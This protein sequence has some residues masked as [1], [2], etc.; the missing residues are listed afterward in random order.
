MKRTMIK[1]MAAVLSV[2]LTGALFAGCGKDDKAAADTKTA[3]EVK[4]VT[5]KEPLK[6][7]K[8]TFYF[9]GDAKKDAR[10]V[11]DEVERKTKDSLN[12]KLEFNWVPWNDWENKMNV[13]AAAGDK[14]E[15]QF[16]ADWLTLNKFANRGALL[17]IKD[18][19]P[20]YAPNLY[21]KYKKEDLLSA[22]I[23]GKL[24]A[25]PW[26][27]PKTERRA[28]IVREDLRKKHGIP[29][30]KTFEDMEVFFKTIKEKEPAITPYMPRDSVLQTVS[31]AFG[32]AVL[33]FSQALVYKWDDPKMK[34]TAWEQTPEFKKSI[35]MFNKWYTQG[36]MPKDML[37]IKDTSDKLMEAGKIASTT[38]LWD[39]DVALNKKTKSSHPDWAFKS[40]NMYPDKLAPLSGPLNN[41]MVF[42]ANAGNPERAMMFLEW[43]HANQENYD[44]L[45]YGIK[46][47]HY[48]LKGEAVSQP[49]GITAATNGYMGWSARHGLWDIQFERALDDDPPGF[50]DAYLANVNWKNN[51]YYPHQGFTPN[52]ES[53]KTET[54][55]LTAYSK[56]MEPLTRGVDSPAKAEE[57]I[58]K[59]KDMG[60]NKIV[61]EAQ[62]Q[63]D[64]WASANKK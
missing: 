19:L 39:L 50:K 54:A 38:Q 28:F 21:K 29:E 41:A 3:G 42:N 44:L 6:E 53:M 12:I 58:K 36:Y 1:V 45:Q 61:E 51:K 15:C 57:Y 43:V 7:V 62:K 49:S 10:K 13:L 37:T 35:E 9:P 18:I 63:L 24:V 14:Y 5:Q 23:G 59:L 30:I 26:I 55:Q 34:I 31:D 56:E 27:Y 40:Y 64:A 20:K 52:F 8:L 16:D 17:D 25:I 60:R 11:L 46:G 4:A 32:Y 48:T 33:S 47:E 22:T 2:A